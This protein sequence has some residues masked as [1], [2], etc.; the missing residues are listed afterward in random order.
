MGPV[1]TA[2]TPP[3]DPDALAILHAFSGEDLSPEDAYNALGGIRNMAGQS[4]TAAIEAQG[5]R[6]A[7][8]IEAQNA[9]LAGAIEAQNAKLAGA[10][11]A[12]S[13]KTESL[14][15]EIGSLRWMIG[16]GFTLLALLITLL[17]LLD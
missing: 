13:T 2:A 15:S 10:I 3:T 17:R 6:F 7:A 11:E 4:V 5:A 8:A 9:K 16:L 12:Q 14:R 1:P